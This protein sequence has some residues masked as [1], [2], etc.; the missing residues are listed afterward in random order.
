MTLININTNIVHHFDIFIND[1][2]NCHINDKQITLDLSQ[3][4]QTLQIRHKFFKSNELEVTDNDQI[5][6]TL[7]PW[8]IILCIVFL[9]LTLYKINFLPMLIGLIFPSINSLFRLKKQ[10]GESTNTRHF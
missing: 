1:K 3:Q 2:L 9:S 7:N 10:N 5:K 8:V 6:V 4:P